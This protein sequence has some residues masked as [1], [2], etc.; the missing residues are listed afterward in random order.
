MRSRGRTPRCR[1]RRQ[2]CRPSRRARRSASARRPRSSRMPP[3]TSP[4]RR[5]RFERLIFRGRRT[6]AEASAS[7]RIRRDRAANSAA[8]VP[9]SHG[10]SHWFESSN[11]QSL[12]LHKPKLNKLSRPYRAVRPRTLRGAEDSAMQGARTMPASR[13]PTYRQQK[14]SGQAVYSCA[15]IDL[16]G[17]R[18]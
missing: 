12:P 5:R 14:Q 2:R 18:N 13:L 16:I 7:R 6:S 15:P 9:S 10:G 4:R 17:V 8:R 1:V 3:R 11:A